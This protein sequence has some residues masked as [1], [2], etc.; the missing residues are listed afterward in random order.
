VPDGIA[1]LEHGRHRNHAHG[2]HGGG[3]SA[4]NRAKNGADKNDRVGEAPADGAKKLAEGIEKIFGKAASLENGAH[5][6]E[7]GDRQ[8]KV[9]RDDAEQLIGQVAQEIW[10][11]Q[12]ELDADKSEK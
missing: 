8:Q 5:E 1:V 10:P 9:I 3:N 12:T 7:E 11:D 6:G 4:S 2:N